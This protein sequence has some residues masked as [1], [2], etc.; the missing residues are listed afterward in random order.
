MIGGLKCGTTSLHHYLNLHPEVGM[1]RPEELNFPLPPLPC[2]LRAAR[3]AAPF[4]GGRPGAR[5]ELTALHQPAPLPGRRRPDAR[6]R[7]GARIVYM[8][9]DPID[10]MLSHYVHNAG[11]GYDDRPLEVAFSD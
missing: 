7:S 8:V 4:R 10:R 9:R 1:S 2:P 3:S 5:R 11:G 6:A